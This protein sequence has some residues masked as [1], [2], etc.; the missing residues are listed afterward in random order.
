M[1]KIGAA[2]QAILRHCLRNLRVCNIDI[3]DERDL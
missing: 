3:T 2:I 1:M